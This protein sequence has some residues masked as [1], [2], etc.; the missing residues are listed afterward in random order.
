MKH[1]STSDTCPNTYCSSST[2]YQITQNW[3]WL[4]CPTCGGLSFLSGTTPCS[5]CGGVGKVAM[6]ESDAVVSTP[7]DIWRTAVLDELRHIRALVERDA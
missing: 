4:I 7:R 1:T 6:M 2:A 3:T 5:T